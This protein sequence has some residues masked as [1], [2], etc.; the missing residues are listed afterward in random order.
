MHC[1]LL[2]EA[3]TEQVALQ[4]PQFVG[5]E[6]VSVHE[7][8]QQVPVTPAAKGHW[9]P[10]FVSEHVGMGRHAPWLQNSPA[11][12]ARPHEPQFVGDVRRSAQAAP[13]QHAPEA[14]GPQAWLGFA[15]V[16]SV[17]RQR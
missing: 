3:P 8:P 10:S 14:K 13:P 6:R 5:L 16:Q 17:R 15:P 1:A 4:T 9:V 2:H 11:M 7:P 12:H